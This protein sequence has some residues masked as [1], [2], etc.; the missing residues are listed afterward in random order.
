MDGGGFPKDYVARLA[1]AGAG[2]RAG[3]DRRLAAFFVDLMP[4]AEAAFVCADP[5][6]AA[7]A[8]LDLVEHASHVILAGDPL[9]PTAR[10]FETIR[11]R[12]SGHRFSRVD[13]SD[14]AALAPA[15]AEDSRLLWVESALS[16]AWRQPDITALA[17]VAGPREVRLAVDNRAVGLDRFNPFAVGADLVVE[18][19]PNGLAVVLT[20]DRPELMFSRDRLRY[21]RDHGVGAAGADDALAAF[22]ALAD[23]P[24]ERVAAATAAAG[25]ADALAGHPAVLRVDYPGRACHPDHAAMAAAGRRP[26]AMLTVTLRGGGPAA[27]KVQAGLVGAADLAAE[28]TYPAGALPQVPAPIRA[29]LGLAEGALRVIAGAGPAEDLVA[30]F[31]AALADL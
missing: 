8:V 19:A 17:A 5:V 6:A 12:T 28:V 21:F 4:G 16:P 20:A 24:A 18:A 9:A 25:L 15:L 30:A 7:G 1:A 26:A 23:W 3:A 29:E 13:L 14:P 10:Y 11:A 22:A 31:R 27:T 2:G